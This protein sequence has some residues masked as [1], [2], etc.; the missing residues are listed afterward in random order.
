MAGYKSI[1]PFKP[2]PDSGATGTST[3]SRSVFLRCPLPVVLT[4]A[5]DSSR[6]YYRNG[7]VP[8]FR[9]VSP[10]SVPINS[11]GVTS[12]TTIGGGGGGG[13]SSGGSGGGSTTP[14]TLQQVSITT[15]SLSANKQFVSSFLVSPS[16]QLINLS[17]TKGCRVRLYGTQ[18]AQNGDLGRG[19]DVPP[20]A[21]TTQN[22]ITDFV[23]DTSP[24]QWTYQSRTGANGDKPSSSKIY[25]TVTNIETTS[26]VIVVTL[27]Y[28]PT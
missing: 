8:Q 18:T 27:G 25:I 28:V 13:S 3:L 6:Q 14:S 17:A 26:S 10:Q 16:F 12:A 2:S 23:F 1:Q 21:G 5:T 22:L 24:F 4:G 11:S 19:L 7:V 9:W 20:A 15:P